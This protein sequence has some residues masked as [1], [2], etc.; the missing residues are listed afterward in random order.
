MPWVPSTSSP[1]VICSQARLGSLALQTVARVESR[2]R[3]LDKTVRPSTTPAPVQALTYVTPASS[4]L[5]LCSNA[6]KIT[7]CNRWV[8]APLCVESG[9]R[10][11]GRAGGVTAHVSRPGALIAHSCQRCG[12][13]QSVRP[14]TSFSDSLRRCAVSPPRRGPGDE[15]D[16]AYM[17]GTHSEAETE[18]E[19][20]PEAEATATATAIDGEVGA[21]EGEPEGE[22]V[23]AE[24]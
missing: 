8:W 6:R 7:V 18:F 10:A 15:I 23:A 4:H 1:P 22:P 17:F 24:E 14:A 16:L 12:T 5:P 9:G 19:P 13:A 21:P 2:Q 11:I 3:D 20:E